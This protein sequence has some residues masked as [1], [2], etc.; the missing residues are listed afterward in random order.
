VQQQQ[1]PKA[2]I[3]LTLQASDYLRKGVTKTE[4]SGMTLSCY[5]C[6]ARW[7]SL[8]NARRRAQLLISKL[9]LNIATLTVK[10][11]VPGAR[12]E[13]LRPIIPSRLRSKMGQYLM[14]RNNK[15]VDPALINRS[16]EWNS[17]A[18]VS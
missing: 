5:I 2:V 3:S 14:T 18:A 4:M 12:G 8:K 7:R 16:I 6:V 15:I 10:V 1:P 11:R 17:G 9:I 13:L